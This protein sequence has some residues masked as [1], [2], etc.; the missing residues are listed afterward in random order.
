MTFLRDLGKNNVTVLIRKAT[1]SQPEGGENDTLPNVEHTK[2]R[3]P[4]SK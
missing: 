4:V 1:C 3:Q 2:I